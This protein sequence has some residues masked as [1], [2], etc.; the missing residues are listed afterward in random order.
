MGSRSRR[1]PRLWQYNQ[2]IQ[3]GAATVEELRRLKTTQLEPDTTL[4]PSTAAVPEE[5]LQP[6][7][8]LHEKK[9]KRSAAW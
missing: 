5:L 4:A 6:E 1:S 9:Y 2:K 3:I 7:E 8:F